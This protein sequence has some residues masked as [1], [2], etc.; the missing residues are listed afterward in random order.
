MSTFSLFHTYSKI[1]ILLKSLKEFLTENLE[2]STITTVEEN[3]E[4]QVDEMQQK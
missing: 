2:D 3:T 4:K 1:Q